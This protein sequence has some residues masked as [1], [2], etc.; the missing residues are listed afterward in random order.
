LVAEPT[1]QFGEVARPSLS[2]GS[3]FFEQGR[4]AIILARR[5]L[6]GSCISVGGLHLALTPGCPHEWMSQDSWHLRLIGAAQFSSLSPRRGR[7]L[8]EHTLCSLLSSRPT[9]SDH[10][11]KM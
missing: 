2:A 11:K 1:R 4:Q 9:P 3:F 5:P 6:A 7:P 8:R 10:C